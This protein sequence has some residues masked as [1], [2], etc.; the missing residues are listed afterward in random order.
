MVFDTFYCFT[1]A[2]YNQELAPSWSGR[3]VGEGAGY[4]HTHTHARRY[5]HKSFSQMLFQK[6]ELIEMRLVKVSVQSSVH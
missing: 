4:T 3:E 1:S 6:S 2:W 5:S